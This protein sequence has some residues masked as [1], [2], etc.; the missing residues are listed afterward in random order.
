MSLNSYNQLITNISQ[1]TN[2]NI[3]IDHDNVITIDTLNNRLGI[4]TRYP[5]NELDVC[6]TILCNNIIFSNSTDTNNINKGEIS[7]NILN[8]EQIK[9]IHTSKQYNI[10]VSNIKSNNIDVSFIT[11]KEYL[12]VSR[13]DVSYINIKN[14]ATIDCSLIFTSNNGISCENILVNNIYCSEPSLNIIGNVLISGDLS[15]NGVVSGIDSTGKQLSD[16]RLKHNEINI[17]N[18]LE[19][20]RKLNPQ[21]YQKT[22][23]FKHPDFSGIVNEHYI[24]ETGLIA[25]DVYKINDVSYTV[26]VGDETKP[27]YLNYNDLFVYTIAGL[28]ELDSFVQKIPEY[29]SIEN[30]ANIQTLLNNQNNIIARLN[31]K[32]SLLENR[33]YLLE[34]K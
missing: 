20:I 16:D 3:N 12:D 5:N 7:L 21:K 34:R 15:V 13:I 31:N 27:Y 9:S 19:I 30:L 18:G 14:D 6:G 8:I 4:K 23:N 1:V 24:I 28:K 25:Q 29:T 32:I 10:D 2:Q 22:K 26:I 11:L 33:I 17:V